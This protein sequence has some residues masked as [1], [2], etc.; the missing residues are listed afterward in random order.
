MAIGVLYSLI[1][2]EAPVN[3]ENEGNTFWDLVL[4]SALY[5]QQQSSL[6]NHIHVRVDCF[7]L[8]VILHTA[9]NEC[10]FRTF[11][12]VQSMA[13]SYETDRVAETD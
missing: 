7:T 5:T 6:S 13:G 11:L 8:T 9:S 3:T 12:Y 2:P 10:A 4:C 1:A